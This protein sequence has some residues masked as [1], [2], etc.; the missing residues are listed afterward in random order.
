MF[1]NLIH[2]KQTN[3]NLSSETSVLINEMKGLFNM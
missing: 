2:N 3:A 1:E